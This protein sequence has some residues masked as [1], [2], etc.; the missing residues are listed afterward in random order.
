M[1]KEESTYRLLTNYHNFF[2]SLLKFKKFKCSNF[3]AWLRAIVSYNF[4]NVG[5]AKSTQDP[6]T[7]GEANISRKTRADI[8]K[9]VRVLIYI[10]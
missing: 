10:N 6:V 4:T 1:K 3:F 9:Q 2:L 8:I 7:N 5:L